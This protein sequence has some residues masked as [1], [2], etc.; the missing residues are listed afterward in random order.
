MEQQKH[1]TGWQALIDFQNQDSDY[2]FSKALDVPN[3]NLASANLLHF[4]E[5][6]P[7]KSS[8]NTKLFL[9]VGG[10]LTSE[11]FF[12]GCN[13]SRHSRMS[14]C[15]NTIRKWTVRNPGHETPMDRKNF[16]NSSRSSVDEGKPQ[17]VF[18]PWKTPSR[19]TF[20]NSKTHIRKTA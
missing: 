14:W 19:D 4:F 17:S 11:V 18:R 10:Y 20:F 1:N 9:V 7:V 13:S 2:H 5:M 8:K 12:K 16:S 6:F 3:L 15:L